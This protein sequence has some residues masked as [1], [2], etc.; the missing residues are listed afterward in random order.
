MVGET[1]A[2]PHSAH[3]RSFS[4]WRSLQLINAVCP[5]LHQLNPLRPITRPIVGTP[6][7]VLILMPERRLDHV[8]PETPFFNIELAAVISAM[9]LV[10]N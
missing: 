9:R 2:P 7:F 10:S 3:E 4:S 5:R 1:A 8:G 6:D